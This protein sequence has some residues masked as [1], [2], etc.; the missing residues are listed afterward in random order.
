MQSVTFF[1]RLK[2]P[3]NVKRATRHLRNLDG[4]RTFDQHTRYKRV[5]ETSGT[6]QN[7]ISI[8]V[9]H[10]GS[11]LFDVWTVEDGIHKESALLV[12]ESP[13]GRLK[14]GKVNCFS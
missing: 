1:D 12:L 6:Y 8:G 14:S 3:S 4:S 10:D 7:G 13:F 9:T 2:L 11:I 5:S